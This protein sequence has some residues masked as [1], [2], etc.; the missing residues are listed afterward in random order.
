M[1]IDKP[2]LVELL[3]DKTGMQPEDV[4]R[5]LDQLIERIVDA[6][7]RGKALEI[8]DFGLFYFD[9]SGEL[10]FDAAE[11]L[12]TE[13]SFK[14]AGMKPVEL[15]PERD[16][17][18]PP[19]DI[20]QGNEELDSE[21]DT[22]PSKP[23]TEAIEEDDAEQDPF[24]LDDESEDDF[25]FLSDIEEPVTETEEAD[26][27]A[28]AVVPEEKPLKKEKSSPVKKIPPRKKSN[29]GFIAIAA[30]LLLVILIGGTIWFMDTLNN[31]EETAETSAAELPVL[32]VPDEL[33]VITEEDEDNIDQLTAIEEAE[34]EDG[35]LPV[36]Q[37][38]ETEVEEEI[39]AVPATQ[40]QISEQPLYGL[41]GAVLDEANDG[42]SIVIH[43]FNT[44]E[45]ARTTAATLTQDGY[46]TLVNSRTVAGNSMWRVSVG[47]FETLS[48][49]QEAA[50]QLPTPYNT[51]NF[52]HRI[53]IN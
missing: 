34:T 20:Q 9:E 45:T 15:K 26:E 47:Q 11:E 42:Y 27:V 32:V 51:Q 49:A 8:K 16:S 22:V 48:D 23:I 35:D 2:K 43:S 29:A 5:Q 19:L 52:I 6:A 36:E 12:S 30:I 24:G 18:M 10:K 14:Y 1:N 13:I 4:E 3:V 53:Q 40:Q 33:S 31:S 17:S 41:R 38:P 21:P 39:D 37:E 7:N 46:R 25:D 28:A 50:R 44:E